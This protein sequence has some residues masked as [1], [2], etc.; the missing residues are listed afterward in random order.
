M[1]KSPIILVQC[2][3]ANCDKI[4]DIEPPHEYTIGSILFDVNCGDC[5]CPY[6]KV[7][8]Q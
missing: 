3:C 1:I 2:K 5:G 7:M 8:D 6:W 4:E